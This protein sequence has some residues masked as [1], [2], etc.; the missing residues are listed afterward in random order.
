MGEAGRRWV[1]VKNKR[2]KNCLLLLISGIV[3]FL[4]YFIIR[5]CLYCTAWCGILCDL[6]RFRFAAVVIDATL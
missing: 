5:I 1:R 3:V 6:V 4:S 2:V